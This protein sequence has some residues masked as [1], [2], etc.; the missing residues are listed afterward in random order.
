MSWASLLGSRNTSQ[1]LSITNFP[2][3]G[4]VKPTPIRVQEKVSILRA[5]ASVWTPPVKEQRYSE[6]ELGAGIRL[7]GGEYGSSRV[8]GRDT[9]TKKTA[10]APNAIVD[11]LMI[12]M[13]WV[14]GHGLGARLQGIVEPIDTEA[15][16]VRYNINAIGGRCGIGF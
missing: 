9:I 4:V 10:F 6:L 2:T 13:G 7:G 12:K 1:S 5:E 15:K 16:F 8:L 11:G 14:P 3:L